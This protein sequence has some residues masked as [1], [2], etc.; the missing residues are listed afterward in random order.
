[1]QKVATSVLLLTFFCL[2]LG[3]YTGLEARMLE[4]I[5]KESICKITKIS[6]SKQVQ[7]V[8]VMYCQKA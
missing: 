3:Q 8:A 7:V 6:Q 1:M 5:P 2:A 4:Y